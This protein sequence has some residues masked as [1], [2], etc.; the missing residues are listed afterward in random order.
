MILHSQVEDAQPERFYKRVQTDEL[1]PVAKVLLPRR[2]GDVLARPRLLNHLYDMVDRKLVLVSAPA[3]YGKT[4]MLIDFGHDL[5]HPVCWYTLDPSD[6][7][8]RTFVEHLV[9]SIQHRFPDFGKRTRQALA[10]SPDLAHGAPGVINV[11]VNEMVDVIP[12]WFVL[13]LDDYHWLGEA[14]EIGA[15]LARWLAYQT[16][17]FL[18]IIASRTI[19]ALPSIIQLAAK[20]EVGGLGLKDLRF[21]ASEIQELLTQNYGLHI[22]EREAEEMATQ[23][24]GWITGILLTA[25]TMWQGIL[26]RLVQANISDQPVYEYL[27]QEVL[28]QQSPQVQNFLTASSILQEMSPALCQE[29]LGLAEAERFLALLEERNLFVTRL[30]GEWYRYHHLFQDYLQ[31]RLKREQESRWI[32]LHRRA[33]HWFEGQGRPETAV[34]HYLAIGAGE[35]AARVMGAAARDMF[36]AGR[37]ETLMAWKAALSPSLHERTPRLVLFQARA[38]DRLGQRSEALALTEI[39]ERGYRAIGD[40]QGLAFTL[41][42]RCEVWQGLGR[43]QEA[44]VLGE[45]VLGLIEDTGIPVTYEA[46]RILGKSALALGQLEQGETYLRRA[47]VCCQEQGGDFERASIQECLADCLWRRGDWSEAIAVLRQVVT[48]WRELDDPGV[49][50]GALNDLGFYLQPTGEYGEALALLNESLELARRTGHRRHEA[51]ALL[52]LAE[53]SRD[54]GALERALGACEEGLVIA[55]E[56]GDGFL[57]AY[58]REAL[59]L[60]HR[61]RGDYGHARQAI[62][63]AIARAQE[64]GSEYQ[65][66]R[67]GASRG[68]IQVESGEVEAGLAELTRAR[69]RLE[70]IGAQ[71]EL[72]RAQFYIAWALYRAGREAEALAALQQVLA[73]ADPMGRELLFVVEGRRVLPL[74][75]QAH[76]QGIGG[77]EVAAL[78]ARARTFD[79][80][81]QALLQVPSLSDTVDDEPLRIYGFGQ[82]RVERNGIEIPVSEWEASATRYL[83]FYL[84]VHSYQTRDQIAAVLWPELAAPKVK[85]TFHTTKFRLKRALGRDTL[86]FDG[87]GYQIHPEL[88]YWFDVA[89]F[90]RLLDEN[91]A[92]R[93]VESLQQAIDLYQG[94]F[95]EDCYS[96]WCMPYREALRE[97]YLEA[98]DE[99]AR[100]LLA[101]RQYRRTIQTLRHGLELDDLREEFHRRLMYTYALSGRRS[102]AVTQ[103]E[104]CAEILARELGADPSPQTTALYRRILD[105][106]PID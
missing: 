32:E 29:V 70:Q 22:P 40:S 48:T 43:F 3:G 63:Q 33:A 9:L 30:E 66:G 93:R 19:P 84:L 52:S 45:A 87:R 78:L 106:L 15:I 21:S 10:A 34:H 98:L 11:L 99:L 81:A 23:S 62:E 65:L 12:S 74:L 85:A 31:A 39:A 96:D 64:Q 56:L 41:L 37:L 14:P 102:Q 72:A 1:E 6:R 7:D 51:L 89:E 25:H 88:D 4:T 68:L 80:Y 77:G 69:E 2:R 90:E 27:A 73:T 17:Q 36:V 94:D 105:G 67:Y 53:L 95:L 92:G 101:R 42:H 82:G 57:S 20:N 103:Y 47:L 91:E 54:L 49:L 13:V 76:K 55:D 28:Y 24:E 83:L 75:E 97:R 35:D 71:G 61:L 46:L 16:G 50:A 60:I 100:L 58:G 5:E 79:S 59:G 26:E 104:R 44:M 8:P 86:Y 38:A 18:L